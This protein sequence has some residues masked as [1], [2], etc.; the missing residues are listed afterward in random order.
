MHIPHMPSCSP[1][2][3]APA[4]PCTTSAM[5]DASA[6]SATFACATVLLLLPLLITSS[7]IVLLAGW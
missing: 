3:E 1:Y 7:V 2:L 6:S 5:S 4:L